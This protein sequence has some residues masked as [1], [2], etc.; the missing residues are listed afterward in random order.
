MSTQEIYN[1]MQEEIACD[2]SGNLIYDG[3]VL[4][5]EYDGLEHLYNGLDEHLDIVAHDDKEIIEDFLTPYDDFV[6]TEPETHDT[7][8]YF[9]IEK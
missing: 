1:L 7:F 5:W 9:Y 6:V 4:K 2:L 8:I 3:N